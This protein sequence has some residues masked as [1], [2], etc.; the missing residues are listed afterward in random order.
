METGACTGNQAFSSMIFI[1]SHD[2]GK[3][4]F[5]FY[6]GVTPVGFTAFGTL[7]SLSACVPT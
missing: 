2:M 5:A 6:C 7:A 4:L 3:Q 1:R